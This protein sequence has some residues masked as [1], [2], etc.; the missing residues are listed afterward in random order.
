M[1][2]L[3]D[4][5]SFS[6][7]PQLNWNFWSSNSR[8]KRESWWWGVWERFHLLRGGEGG[9][10]GR[11]GHVQYSVLM[12]SSSD[13]VLYSD[14]QRTC[15][16]SCGCTAQHKKRAERH[17]DCQNAT[18]ILTS[19]QLHELLWDRG[20]DR[21]APVVG[22]SDAYWKQASI[23]PFQYAKRK[24]IQC[25]HAQVLVL[26]TVQ[27]SVTSQTVGRVEVKSVSRRP[28]VAQ[29]SPTTG[30]CGGQSD[31]GTGFSPIILLF[32]LSVP[33]HQC[34]VLLHSSATD[35]VQP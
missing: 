10:V 12:V 33:F 19:G 3:D 27:R 5:A 8:E 15:G 4:T 20:L 2:S 34:T 13:V 32:P 35:A 18:V 16:M 30:I 31:T 9:C 6:L 11:T 7:H 23:P 29:A 26:R 25:R 21:T 28:L 1:T 24:Y 17:L 14:R 22:P